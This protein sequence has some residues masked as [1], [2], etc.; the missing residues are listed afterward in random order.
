[1]PTL[2]RH[3]ARSAAAPGSPHTPDT[4]AWNRPP[5]LPGHMAHESLRPACAADTGNT[6]LNRCKSQDSAGD[7]Y[8]IL[9]VIRYTLKRRDR[10][11]AIGEDT[12]HGESIR[13]TDLALRCCVLR[14]KREPPSHRLLVPISFPRVPYNQDRVL[15]PFLLPCDLPFHSLY[16][17]FIWKTATRMDFINKHSRLYLWALIHYFFHFV[18]RINSSLIV[19]MKSFSWDQCAWYSHTNW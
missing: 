16:G 18:C 10:R 15:L 12:C 13:T 1:M 3:T 4:N 19:I 5:T 8:T 7:F 11:L 14:W 17:L 2:P 6:L 9:R